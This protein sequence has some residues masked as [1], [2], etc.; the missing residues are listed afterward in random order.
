MVRRRIDNKPVTM[1]A[2]IDGLI[3]GELGICRHT[4][5]KQSTA[6]GQ[7][8]TCQVTEVPRCGAYVGQLPASQISQEVDQWLLS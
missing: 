2:Y 6:A 8:I 7:V 5:A 4:E 3:G 1:L